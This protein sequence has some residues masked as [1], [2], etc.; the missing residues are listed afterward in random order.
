M[1]KYQIFFFFKNSSFSLDK[2]PLSSSL[3]SVK[4]TSE[5]F[6]VSISQC[7]PCGIP[8]VLTTGIYKKCSIL[9]LL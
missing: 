5:A 9:F 7:V 8:K 2:D 4:A 1:E 6:K 3:S